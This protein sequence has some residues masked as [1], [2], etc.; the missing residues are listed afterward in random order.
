MALKAVGFDLDDTLYDRNDVYRAVYN[1]MEKEIVET[2]VP[3]PEFITEFEKHSQFAYNQFMNDEIDRATYRTQRVINTYDKFGFEITE[4]QAQVY[5]D[6]YV[7]NQNNLVFRADVVG[8]IEDLIQN[9]VDVF[10]LTNGPSAGQRNKIEVLNITNW[11]PEDRI[12]VSAEVGLTKPDVE[13]F[14]YIEEKLN[15]KGKD[16]L[17]VGDDFKSDII[18]SQKSNWHS[19]YFSAEAKDFTGLKNVTHAT[20]F[21]EVSDILKDTYNIL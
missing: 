14:E 7:K 20:S 4:E 3:F 8:L 2:N 16:I 10:I 9:N 11:F 17:Y 5:E 13:I 1:V 12:F 19:I 21:K 6:N 15:L 18:G